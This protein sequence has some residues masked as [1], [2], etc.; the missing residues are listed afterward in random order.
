MS[1]ECEI[2]EPTEA[3][4]D[5]L[6][7]ELCE[8]DRKLMI[9]RGFKTHL[10]ALRSV[11]SSGELVAIGTVDKKPVVAVGCAP[12]TFQNP[13]A[14][15]GFIWVMMSDRARLHVREIVAYSKQII[16]NLLQYYDVLVSATDDSD[17]RAMRY[18]SFLGFKK[19]GI[20]VEKDGKTFNYLVK[21]GI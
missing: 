16:E 3:L 15:E 6:A 21:Y 14:K 4:V 12:T 8:S 9:Q 17:K 5:E 18:D 11:F 10:E 2:V 7:S 20:S 13:L 19:S 1:S